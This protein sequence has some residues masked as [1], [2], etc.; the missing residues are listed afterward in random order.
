[1]C[2]CVCVCLCVC[3]HVCV[4]VCFPPYFLGMEKIFENVPKSVDEKN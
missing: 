3:V 1:M 2:V 4:H